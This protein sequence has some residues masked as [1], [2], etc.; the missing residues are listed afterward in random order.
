MS[1]VSAMRQS[2]LDER[3]AARRESTV[4]AFRLTA[5]ASPAELQAARDA[6]VLEHR[7]VADA[8]ARRF[9]GRGQDADDIRQVAYIGLIK[10]ASRFDPAKGEDFVSFAVP[11]ISGEIKRHLRD[12]GW[13]IRPPRHIQELRSRA[14]TAGPRLAQSLGRSPS[15]RELAEYL[16]VTVDALREAYRSQDGLTPASL[17]LP[18]SEDDQVTL[19]DAIGAVDHRQAHVELTADLRAAI[20][21]LSVRERRI[22]QLRFFE[23]FTQQQIAA[24]LGVT[25]M[26]VSRLLG[27]ILLRL[28][29]A[30]G[31]TVVALQQD[32]PG[33]PISA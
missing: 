7:D 3:R 16:G 2:A 20:R 10:A 29:A 31:D 15:T 14:A 24:D 23:D 17:D 27:K 5:S 12:H 11:T 6:A 21:V 30:L 8:I 33:L 19:G 25:Q 4:S 18:I 32:E 9:I 22:V 1:V 26:Q 13:F 28:R